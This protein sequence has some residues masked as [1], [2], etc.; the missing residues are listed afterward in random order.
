MVI[1]IIAILAALLL[2]ALAKAK[3]KAQCATCMNNMNE[4][5]KASAGMYTADNFDFFAP[6]PDDGSD[7]IGHEWCCGNVAGGMP[8]GSAF[9]SSD[10]CNLDIIK[11]PNRCML[12]PYLAANVDVF[13]CPADP[14]Y[15][16][17]SGTQDTSLLGKRVNVTRSVSQNQ[18]VGSIC[19]T[20]AMDGSGHSGKPLYDVN[21]PWLD[22]TH[23]HKAGKPYATFGKM[24]EFGFCSPSVIFMHVDENPYSINDAALA[25]SAAEHVIID[26][27]GDLHD[28]SCGFS[29]CDGHSEMHKWK[30]NLMHLWTYPG[31]MPGGSQAA[32]GPIGSMTYYD[33]FWLASHATKNTQTG[34]V[35]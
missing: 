32:A 7:T 6:N 19:L 20:F 34:L 9:D 11:D 18:G 25:V 27:P 5:S 23:N 26:Y 17:Y 13:H 8:A 2:P 35:P 3:A 29:F 33:W 12:A 10:A 31:D 14:R 15:G 22:G 1:A 4:L 28:N 24:T 21:G 16:T 30:S